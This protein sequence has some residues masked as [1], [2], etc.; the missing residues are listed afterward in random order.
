MAAESAA[1]GGLFGIVSLDTV[2]ATNRLLMIASLLLALWTIYCAA[3]AGPRRDL[4]ATSIATALRSTGDVNQLQ[5][6][7]FYLKEVEG[8]NIF[9]PI[10]AKTEDEKQEAEDPRRRLEEFAQDLEVQGVSWNDPDMVMAYD[11]RQRKMLFLRQS[12]KIGN[13]EIEVR[14]VSPDRVRLGYKDAEIEI[15]TRPSFRMREPGDEGGR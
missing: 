12:Q 8:R 15:Y 1:V 10:L 3:T 5:T 13:T 2:R 11:R 9:K 4:A 7:A 6:M 14:E